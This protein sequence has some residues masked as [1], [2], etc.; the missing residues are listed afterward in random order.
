MAPRLKAFRLRFVLLDIRIDDAGD[1]VFVLLDFLE[2]TVVFLFL[3]FDFFEFRF[4]GFLG[5]GGFALFAF[6]FGVDFDRG[7]GFDGF[8]FGLVF[9]C[10]FLD[11]LFLGLFGFLVVGFRHHGFYRFRHARAALLQKHFGFEGEGAF[12]AFDRTLLQVVKTSRATGADAFG[13]KIGLDQAG[14]SHMWTKGRWVCHEPVG[15]SKS[16]AGLD[17]HMWPGLTRPSIRLGNRGPIIGTRMAASEH[18]TPLT[19]RKSG[20]LKGRVAAPGDKSVSHRALILGALAVG[21]TAVSGLLEADDVLNTAAAMR[22]LGADVVRD[23]SGKWRIHGVGVGG[24][25]EPSDV[26]DFGNSGTGVRLTMGAMATTPITA[27]FTGDASLKRRPMRRVL[28]PL[29]LFGAV[30][31]TREGGLLPLTLFGARQPLPIEHRLQVASAQV[32][33]ALILAALNVPGRSTIIER[34]ATRDHTERMLKAFGADIRVEAAEDGATAISIVGEAELVPT[35]IDVPS[36]PSSAAFPLVAALIVP[37]S[38]IV[39]ENV[40]LNPRRI[41]LIET[42]REMG[43][44]IEI[45]NPRDNGG[46]AV[47]DLAVRHSALKG[48]DVPAMRAPT[49]IDEYP[50]LAVAAAFAEGRTTMRGLEELRVKE[51]DRLSAV[52]A[53]LKANGVRVSETEDGLIVEG[54]GADGVAGGGQVATH[55]DHRI[56][57]SFLVMGLASRAAV[58]VDDGS[59]IATSFPNFQTLMGALGASIEAVPTK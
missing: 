5:R 52:A 14:A 18:F 53:G 13:S 26:L 49:M 12:R 3:V 47:G 6:G 17:R 36:D 1:V 39:L 40:M 15:L 23:G 37:G 10:R 24:F 21:E 8:L 44:D 4:G 20:P 32:K 27:I 29:A 48:V 43:A 25:S 7:L 55:M 33:S 2:Q 19:A 35:R 11:F 22:R 28:D 56:A 50:V 34:A 45:R 57:M 41:G 58:I 46:D 38:D 9:G 42:L 54:A 59:M 16:I 31:E 51:S 30:A